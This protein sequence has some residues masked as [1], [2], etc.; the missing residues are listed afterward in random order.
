LKQVLLLTDI[1]FW[2][3]GAGHRMRIDSL[4]RYLATKV[5][6]T[7]V[8][9]GAVSAETGVAVGRNY[10]I[11]FVILEQEAVIPPEEYGRR[12]TDQG[13]LRLILRRKLGTISF[14]KE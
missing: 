12:L 4:V 6:L 3:K 8:F 11:K 5:D 13:N 2:I 9:V 14:F 10:R 1:N 7:I